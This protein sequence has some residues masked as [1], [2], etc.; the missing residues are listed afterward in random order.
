MQPPDTSDEI[1]LAAPPFPVV[2]ELGRRR[3]LRKGPDRPVAIVEVELRH[4]VG[5][6][7]IGLP[8]GVERADVAPIGAR[9]IAARLAVAA[10]ARAR[11]VMRDRLAVLDQIRDQVLAEVA[12][13]V[14]IVGVAL[15]L[16]DQEIGV[17]DVDPHAR[18]RLVRAARLGGRIL[19]LLDERRDAVALVDMDDAEAR[20]LGARRPRGSRWSRRRPARR[21]AGASARS[22]SCRRGRRRARR[23]T[24]ARSSR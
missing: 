5:Q 3:D 24:W 16:V 15:E 12:A 11:E 4:H 13:R 1:A 19:R 7:D 21:A 6:V 8:I 2:H 22:P 10:H 23:C 18:Q 20:R 9:R 14:R 17:E